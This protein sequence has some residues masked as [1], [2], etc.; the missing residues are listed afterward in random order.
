MPVAWNM[1]F[2]LVNESLFILINIVQKMNAFAVVEN[3]TGY[4]EQENG[5]AIERKD[6]SFIPGII[7]RP[8]DN[9]PLTRP[10][11]LSGPAAANPGLPVVFSENRWSYHFI[12]NYNDQMLAVNIH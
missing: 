6:L 5:I 4:R 1:S 12:F 3:C 8:R 2:Y 10:C 11:S 7:E 9:Y